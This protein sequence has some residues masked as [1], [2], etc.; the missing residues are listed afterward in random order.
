[1]AKRVAPR[2]TILIPVFALL[3]SFGILQTS[4]NRTP[5]GWPYQAW[6]TPN[7]SY[8]FNPQERLAEFEGEKI[9]V[10]S[11]VFLSLNKQVKNKRTNQH[12]Q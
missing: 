11:Q 1:M 8:S 2:L 9:P 3:V 4:L 7:F 5:S 10:P 6:I 12:E